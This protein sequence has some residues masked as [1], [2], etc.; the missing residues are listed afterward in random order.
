MKINYILYA[1]TLTANC[2]VD[3]FIYQIYGESVKDVVSRAMRH[4][5]KTQNR[6]GELTIMYRFDHGGY[7]ICFDGIYDDCDICGSSEIASLVEENM[8]YGRECCFETYGIRFTVK[9]I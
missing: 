2:Y 8:R 7:G 1:E 6:G 9:S 4:F 5:E 3:E